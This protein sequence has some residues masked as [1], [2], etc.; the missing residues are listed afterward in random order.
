MAE[1]IHPT[2]FYLLYK[3]KHFNKRTEVKEPG[4]VSIKVYDMLS[5]EVAT[6]MNEEKPTEILLLS[7]M[8]VNLPV[9]FI[10]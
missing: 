10:Y 5:K 3:N 1:G 9:E 8:E 6:L 4:L 7:L 2:P